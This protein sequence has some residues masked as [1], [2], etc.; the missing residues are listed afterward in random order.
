MISWD[1]SAIDRERLLQVGLDGQFT[2]E[3]L[4]GGHSRLVLFPLDS[5]ATRSWVF[6]DGLVV[7][8]ILYQVRDWQQIDSPHFRFFVSDTTGFHPANIEALE[9][10]LADTAHSWA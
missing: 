3:P 2:V 8:P 10:F 5:L 1:L 7:L 6:R 9:T 4:D